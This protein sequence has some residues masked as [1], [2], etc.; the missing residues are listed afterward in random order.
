MDERVVNWMKHGNDLRGDLLK[1]ARWL[2]KNQRMTP[3]EEKK[4]EREIEHRRRVMLTFE[5]FTIRL[6]AED[7][8]WR[9]YMVAHA[10]LQVDRANGLIDQAEFLAR[11]YA[12][13]D[14]RDFRLKG[15]D[16]AYY[17]RRAAG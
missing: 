15:L 13:I 1:K 3:D 4:L 5:G 17:P 6:K 10:R 12:L 16:D 8:A 11:C 7:L 9:D 14:E 2:V